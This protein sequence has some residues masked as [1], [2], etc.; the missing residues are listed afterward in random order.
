[1]PFEVSF[2]VLDLEKL[3]Q[4]WMGDIRDASSILLM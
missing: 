3:W 1:M 2:S 4:T